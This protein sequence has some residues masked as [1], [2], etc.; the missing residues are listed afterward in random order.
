MSQFIRK[1]S[2]PYLEDYQQYRPFL[3]RDFRCVCAYCERTEFVLGGEEFFEIDHFRPVKRFPEQQTHYPNLYYAC[4]KCNRH[5]GSTWPSDDSIKKSLRFA[6]PCREDMYSEHLEE[7]Q[8][9]ALRAR[10]NTGAYTCAHIQLNRL[11]LVAWRR[12]RRLI[13][14]DLFVLE[15][16]VE[17]LQLMLKAASG[18][19]LR[20]DLQQR[21]AALESTIARLRQQYSL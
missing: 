4:G 1:E 3:R 14:D 10:T 13:A 6:D 2:P 19:E 9:G 5:K 16:L 7:T 20:N 11:A 15:A 21:L 17:D 8:D 12:S 18:T